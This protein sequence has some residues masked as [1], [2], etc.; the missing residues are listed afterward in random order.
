MRIL[1][2]ISEGCAMSQK[3]YLDALEHVNRS[4]SS[5]HVSIPST[6]PV[7]QHPRSPTSKPEITKHLYI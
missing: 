5:L 2:H 3:I 6:I 7:P 4:S 1:Y